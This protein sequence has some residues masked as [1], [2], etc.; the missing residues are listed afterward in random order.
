MKK[1]NKQNRELPTS[2]PLTELKK[3]I[4]NNQTFFTLNMVAIL[5]SRRIAATT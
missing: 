2:S 4:E 3:S 1:T 5:Q